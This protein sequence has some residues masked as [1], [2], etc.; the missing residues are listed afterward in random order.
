MLAAI[1]N[2]EI[3]GK[4]FSKDVFSLSSKKSINKYCS[5]LIE[6][7]D[8]LQVSIDAA[9]EEEVEEE[10]NTLISR[11]LDNPDPEQ[12]FNITPSK[13]Q[14]RETFV[15]FGG[16][17]QLLRL[18]SKPFG[19]TDARMLS[20]ARVR[21]KAEFW[22]EIFVILREVAFALPSLAD[23]LFTKDH[24]I[25]LFTMLSHAVVF[26]NAINLIEE[27]LAART[28]TFLL[29]C[30][31]NVFALIDK[32]SSRQLMHFCR[33]LSL[34][35]F[36]SEDRQIMEGSHVLRSIELLQVRRVDI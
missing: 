4:H 8:S 14:E 21:R 18:F 26:D 23:L 31:P 6:V 22:N 15:A 30:V 35:L 20:N 2:R 9:N 13:R 10:V 3:R 11:L 7:I 24:I 5:N 36:E 33:V 16:L 34:V 19:H 32:F 25:F 28:E 27:I 12:V 1:K 17:H 29:G